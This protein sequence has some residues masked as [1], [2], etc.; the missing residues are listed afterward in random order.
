MFDAFICG[1]IA[2]L[3]VMAVVLHRRADRAEAYARSLAA[4][5]AGQDE[6]IRTMT[7]ALEGA[8]VL[9]TRPTT[10]PDIVPSIHD[11]KTA[12]AVPMIVDDNNRPT[13]PAPAKSEKRIIVHNDDAFLD[14]ADGRAAVYPDFEERDSDD[15]TQVVATVW[16]KATR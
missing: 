1:A 5:V 10:S 14:D 9:G 15:L 11:R 4:R 16:T 7:K 2:V 6:S 3:A 12:V 8:D 13:V